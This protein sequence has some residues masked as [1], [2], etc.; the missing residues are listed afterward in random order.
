MKEKAPNAIRFVLDLIENKFTQPC[1]YKTHT[2]HDF[3]K[4]EY[5]CRDPA[6]YELSCLTNGRNGCCKTNPVLDLA[7]TRR[8]LYLDI[9]TDLKIAV[10]KK[11]TSISTYD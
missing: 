4:R 5:H 2:L 8:Q 6:T 9:M 1:A 7:S 3:S 11:L 10:R